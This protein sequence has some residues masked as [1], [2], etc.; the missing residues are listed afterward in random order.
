MN[1]VERHTSVFF[2]EDRAFVVPSVIRGPGYYSGSGVILQFAVD[3]AELGGTIGR[4]LQLVPLSR[5]DAFA[6]FLK[7][8][9]LRSRKAF[10]R[11][12]RKVSVAL[13]G[14]SVIVTPMVTFDRGGSGSL[15]D[16]VRELPY[17]NLTDV[18]LGRAVLEAYELIKDHPPLPKP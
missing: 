12:V 14:S 5:G 2:Y 7:K 8:L 15:D 11:E 16:H 10:E 1:P 4:S 13:K 3:A 17:D 18:E 6:L 9:G